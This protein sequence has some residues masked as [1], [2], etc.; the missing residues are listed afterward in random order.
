MNSRVGVR[1]GDFVNRKDIVVQSLQFLRTRNFEAAPNEACVCIIT[2]FIKPE[3]HISKCCDKS[4]R[5]SKVQ[6]HIQAY[7][8]IEII[9][10]CGNTGWQCDKV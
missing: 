3:V 9:S 1:L 5:L 2:C 7:I 4:N 6:V 8:V 10:E